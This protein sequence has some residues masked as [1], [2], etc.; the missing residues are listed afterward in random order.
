MVGGEVPAHDQ[1]RGEAPD[2]PVTVGAHGER[3]GA[4]LAVGGVGPGADD[5]RVGRG[6]VD[7]AQ[8]VVGAADV[9]ARP[10]RVERHGRHRSGHGE[11][12]LE[13]GVRRIVERVQVEAVVVGSDR[14]GR[15]GTVEGDRGHRSGAFGPVPEL[16]R[17]PG[18]VPEGAVTAG[19]AEAEDLP[20]GVVGQRQGREVTTS[21][22][23]GE[24]EAR[25][26]GQGL[27]SPE[28][29]L[30]GAPAPCR[31]AA[32]RVDR[33][34]GRTVADPAGR[35][36]DR[37]GVQHRREPL[38]GAGDAVAHQRH[39]GL[40]VGV[41]AAQRVGLGR[42][43][44]RLGV[45]LQRPGLHHGHH[46]HQS[47]AGGQH[48]EHDGDASATPQPG[49]AQ[50]FVVQ[51]VGEVLPAGREERALEGPEDGLCTRVLQE[52]DEQWQPVDGQQ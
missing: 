4:G 47:K 31:E 42:D 6:Q 11:V 5:A 1:D 8:G 20:S 41:A 36:L 50:P 24:G 48:R 35:Q 23:G 38:A 45:P 52:G 7:D 25:A 17:R 12:R 2:Q 34:D 51:L 28:R 22:I 9:Q 15:P 14:H 29:D 37:R 13:R 39:L 30:A 44:P 49:R 18:D 43:L 16:G 21:R 26:A 27:G 32:R 10:H 40:Q 33:E 3:K 19:P 46:R